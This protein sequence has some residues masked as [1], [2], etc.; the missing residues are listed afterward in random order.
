M[1]HLFTFSHRH[2]PS[3]V[4]WISLLTGMLA[5]SS[6]A[7]P[8]QRDNNANE[9]KQ[10]PSQSTNKAPRSSTGRIDPSGK[11]KQM[12]RTAIEYARMCEPELGLPPHIDLDRAV[13]I[14]IFIDGKQVYGNYPTCDNPVLIGKRTVSGSVIQRYEGRTADGVKLPHVLWVAFGRN[15]S[16]STARVVGSVQMIGY[17]KQ[18]GATAFFESG[19]HISP[20]VSL[21]KQTWRMRGRMPWIDDPRE[22]NQAFVPAPMQCIQCHQNDPFITNSFITAAKIPGTEEPVIPILDANSPYH[23]IGGSQWDMRTIT[24][25][26]NACFDCHR[27]GMKTIELFSQSGWDVN[28]HMPPDDPG[29]LADAYQQLLAAWQQGPDKV[30]GADWLIPPARGTAKRIVGTD[31]PH[32]AAFNRNH[33]PDVGSSRERESQ[34]LELMR[35][36]YFESSKHF[37]RQIAQGT[38]TPEEADHELTKLLRK[39]L[40]ASEK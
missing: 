23:V 15:S 38:L 22:F 18:T 34:K 20:W 3:L 39:I 21:D 32:K 12:P 36:R 35:M 40:S 13:E 14:P 37:Q 29:S 11:D 4:I 24:L 19:D 5:L 27:V 28:E 26:D 17:N 7:F 31:Y 8:Q 30:S 1:S 6:K 25:K 16:S 2:T 9:T 33:F 10:A